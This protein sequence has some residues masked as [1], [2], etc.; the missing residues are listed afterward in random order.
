MAKAAS[1]NPPLS[2]RFLYP[3]P[4]GGRPSSWD[5][6][7]DGMETSRD[8]RKAQRRDEILRAAAAVFARRGYHGTTIAGIAAE[9]NAPRSAVGY[10][11][12]ETKEDIALAIVQHQRARW[13]ELIRRVSDGPGSGLEQLLTILLSAALDARRN[14]LAAAAARLTFEQRAAELSF[15]AGDLQWRATGEQMIARSISE[16]D[17]V[18]TRAASEIVTQFFAASYGLV[19]AEDNGFEEP[20]TQYNLCRLWADLLLALGVDDPATMLARLT[21][22]EL[23]D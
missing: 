16:G 11:H 13:A 18:T 22:V 8:R 14:P 20:R 19:T 9:M 5:P 6:Y 10:H 23:P 1:A 12:F 21:V 4:T 15:P 2:D 17:L 7:S 3:G